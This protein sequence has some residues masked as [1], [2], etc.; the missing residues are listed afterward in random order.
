MR[1]GPEIP[2]R[3]SFL[4]VS[5]SGLFVGSGR[6]TSFCDTVLEF[7]NCRVLYNGT[8]SDSSS[9]VPRWR[10][11]YIAFTY[12]VPRLIGCWCRR[13][14]GS[15]ARL[16]SFWGN[17]VCFVCAANVLSVMPTCVRCSSKHLDV[18]LFAKNLMVSP[19]CRCYHNSVMQS[20]TLSLNLNSQTE[21]DQICD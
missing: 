15:L 20:R 13:T 8:T 2:E 18:F 10:L 6:F 19:H 12:F 3:N 11:R 16:R 7:Y 1:S 9:A 17:L 14:Q 5:V 4:S 21:S